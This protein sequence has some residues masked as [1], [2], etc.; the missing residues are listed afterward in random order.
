MSRRSR[1]RGRRAV[2][3]E[4]PLPAVDWVAD[5][6]EELFALLFSVVRQSVQLVLCVGRAGWHATRPVVADPAYQTTRNSH[7]SQPEPQLTTVSGAHR[8]H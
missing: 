3:G 1:K 2:R 4:C 5:Y 8:F 7:E 6:M